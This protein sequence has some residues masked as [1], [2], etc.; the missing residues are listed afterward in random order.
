MTDQWY[1]PISQEDVQTIREKAE[2]LADRI[3]R[4][5]GMEVDDAE[6][7]KQTARVEGILR[8]AMNWALKQTEK[9]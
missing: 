4:P 9:K 3:L 5:L 8:H 7:A 1:L 2:E 6:Y